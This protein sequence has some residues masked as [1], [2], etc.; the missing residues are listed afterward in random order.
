VISARPV[1]LPERLLGGD[2]V[3]EPAAPVVPGENQRRFR[4]KAALRQG[5]HAL[6]R[7]GVA[8]RYGSVASGCSLSAYGAY[9]H[10]TSGRN[11]L[12][13]SA[14]NCVVTTFH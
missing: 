1:A 13:R 10:A 8:A 12:F 2:D 4:P 11:P 9:S 5:L 7:P 14:S 6:P 3:V